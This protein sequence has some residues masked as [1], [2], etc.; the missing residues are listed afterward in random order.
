MVISLNDG[1]CQS[2]VVETYGEGRRPK[3]Y[4]NK[5]G[6]NNIFCYHKRSGYSSVG[7]EHRSYEPGVSGSSPLYRIIVTD[8]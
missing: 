8:I 4:V 3:P 7:L 2:E 1:G 5:C 6:E